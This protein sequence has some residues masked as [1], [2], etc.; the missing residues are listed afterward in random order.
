MDTIIAF[1]IAFA[2]TAYFVKRDRRKART[3]KP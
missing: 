1:S 3:K 2:I